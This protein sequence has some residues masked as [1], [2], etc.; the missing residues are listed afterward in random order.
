MQQQAAT[1]AKRKKLFAALAAG[2]ALIGGGYYAY[3]AL[4]GSKHAVTDNAYVGADVAQVTPLVGG[5]VREVLVQDT[6]QVRR[7]DVLVRLD[8]TDARIAVARAEA[9]LASAIRKVQGLHATDSGLGA[10]I[11]ARAADEA[12]AQ[13]QIASAQADVEKARID[14]QRREA[15]AAS[16]AVSGDELTTRAQRLQHRRGQPPLGPGRACPGGG[17]P[18]RRGR[19]SQRQPR[20]DRQLD[21]RQQPRSARRARRARPG[22]R[23]SRAHRASRA[24][25]RRRLAAPGPGRPARPAGRAC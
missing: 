14:L 19:R 20:A 10:Q 21:G 25:R 22:P 11:A 17:D 9:N 16:G 7:G 23:R 13:A 8:D 3:D 24:D 1:K 2:I 18:Q 15:L 12:R 6:Q 4:V 5:P